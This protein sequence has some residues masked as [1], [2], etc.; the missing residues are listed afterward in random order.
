[1]AVT[2]FKTAQCHATRPMLL[3]EKRSAYA[4]TEEE[5]VRYDGIY[6]I[7]RCW[8]KAGMQKFLVCRYL[9]VRC[10]NAPAPWSTEGNALLLSI[11]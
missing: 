6:R 4:P 8:R 1:M 9:F 11:P 7:A 10:D 3:Q 2:S 5:P